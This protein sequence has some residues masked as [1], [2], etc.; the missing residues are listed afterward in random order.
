MNRIDLQFIRKAFEKLIR[1]EKLSNY[2][3]VRIRKLLDML[4]L[5]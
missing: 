2:E 1:G 4:S 5:G 3:A